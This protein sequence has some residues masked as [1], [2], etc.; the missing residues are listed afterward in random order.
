MAFNTLVCSFDLHLHWHCTR[1]AMMEMSALALLSSLDCTLFK[2][3]IW[4]TSGIEF[5]FGRCIVFTFRGIFYGSLS[6]E[7]GVTINQRTVAERMVR[8][9][10]R[11]SRLVVWCAAESRQ[12]FCLDKSCVACVANAHHT[13]FAD[14][15]GLLRG[16]DKCSRFK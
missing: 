2:G 11:W 14:R 15:Y 5:S 3:F 7:D 13:H 1:F 6:N 16:W 10:A 8:F 4:N 12:R 9:Y